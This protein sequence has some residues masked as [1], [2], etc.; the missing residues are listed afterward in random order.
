MNPDDTLILEPEQYGLDTPAPARLEVNRRDFFKT[1]GCGVMVLFVI[2]AAL[3][4]E[5][6]SA[7]RRGGGRGGAAPAEISAWIHIGEDGTITVYTGKAEVG[8][9]IRTSLTQAVA[10]ELRAPVSSI[11]MVMSDTD[12]VPYDMGTFG[13]MTTPQMAS[14]LH[15][16][17]AAARGV[18][19]DMAAEHFQADRAS[20]TVADGKISKSGGSESVSFGQLTKGQKFTKTVDGSTP[21]TPASDWK[22][23]GTSVPKVDGRDFVTGKHKY[24]SD[25]KLPGMLFGKILRGPT[26]AAKIVSVDTKAAEAMEGVKV[27]R[28]ETGNGT[29]VGAVAP[30]SLQAEYAVNAITAQW[31]APPDQPTDKT[32]F[33][34]IKNNVVAGGGGG[35]GGGRRGGGGAPFVE[36]AMEQEAVPPAAAVAADQTL[37]QTYT[38]AY[39]AHTPLEP[40]A[41]VAD[42]KEDK[43]TVWAGTQRPFGVRS[44]LA[45]E[46]G[47]PEERVRVIVPDTGSGYGGKHTNEAATEAARLSRAVGKPV[48]LV[49][50]REEE[51]TWAW[52]RPA[53]VI[54]VTSG[55]RNDGTLASWEFYNYNSG[56]AALATPYHVPNPVTAF[57]PTRSPLRQTSYRSLAAAANNFARE[58]HMDELARLLKMD[59]LEFR[60]KNLTDSPRD[61]RLRAVFEAAAKAFGWGAVK[62]SGGRGFGIAGGTDKNSYVATCAEVLA[63]TASGTVKVVRAVTAFDCGA[64]VNPNHLKN[65]IEGA[66][67]MGLGG[68]LFEAIQF[69]KGMITNPHLADYRVPHFADAPKIEI[70]LIDR[71]DVAS[72]GAG[73]T[74]IISISPAVGNAILDATNIRL[75][76]MPM[77][78]DGLKA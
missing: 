30:D 63:D 29:F 39:I 60:L 52:F 47:I 46:L 7:G 16:A 5:G 51:F 62:A 64:V 33:E 20:L 31:S 74:P 41:A 54:E 28:E 9:N 65:Q 58:V 43:L 10:E 44:D 34:Y 2:P 25:M 23:A 50:T 70:V 24:S 19:L 59:P 37:K 15:R 40:R 42:W 8:Q 49:W 57:R 61:S 56:N 27:V 32:I 38:V 21:V 1:L 76:H 67:V 26:L 22:I 13:S 35:R 71:K 3:A 66:M 4:Q 18:L 72:A 53:G 6:G 69:E 48:K 78:P 12:L 17:A 45:R 75:R 55:V 14:Q 77:I 36:E 73:E 68:A 11:K